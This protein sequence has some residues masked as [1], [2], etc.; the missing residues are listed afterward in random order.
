MKPPNDVPHQ[1]Q[2]RV[3]VVPGA[4]RTKVAGWLGPVGGELKVT[5]AAVPERGRANAE[6]E[7]L[8]EK[9]LGLKKG[10][11]SVSAGLTSPHK[12]LIISGINSGELIE[13]LAAALVN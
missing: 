9:V 3:K 2:L 5:V 7:R 10:S 4:S 12:V 8:L 11:A 13:R 1:C 6:V